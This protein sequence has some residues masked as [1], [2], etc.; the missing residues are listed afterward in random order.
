M[1]VESGDLKSG[2]EKIGTVCIVWKLKQ[3]CLLFNRFKLKIAF[4]RPIVRPSL[5]TTLQNLTRRRTTRLIWHRRTLFWEAVLH[6]RE[7]I[8][9]FPWKWL[10]VGSK[11]YVTL[12]NSKFYHECTTLCWAVLYEYCELAFERSQASGFFRGALPTGRWVSEI[13]INSYAVTSW[14]GY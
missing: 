1:A 7:V 6:Q 10:Y 9:Y 13:F 12:D 14:R 3:K 4:L 2:T 11:N 5:I 8:L